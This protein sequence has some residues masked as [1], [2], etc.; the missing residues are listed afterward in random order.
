MICGAK[1]R[2]GSPCQKS[3]LQG[4]YRCRLHG[5]LSLSGKD[6]PNYKHGRCTKHAQQVTVELSSHIKYLELL[7]IRLGMFEPSRGGE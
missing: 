7:A 1:T 5:G 3:P 4:K 2:L 6:H